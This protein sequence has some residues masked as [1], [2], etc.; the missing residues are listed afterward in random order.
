VSAIC[1]NTLGLGGAS[2]ILLL[3][4]IHASYS[5]AVQSRPGKIAIAEGKNRRSAHLATSAVPRRSPEASAGSTPSW[6][7]DIQA[8]GPH[9]LARD[10]KFSHLTTNDGLSQGYVTAILQ[11]RRGFMWFATRDGL[12][13][14]DG[15]AF[16]VYKNNPNDPGSLSSNF[17][18]DLIEDDHGDLWVATNT[19]VNKFDPTTERATRYLPDPEN[20]NSIG[21]AGVRSVAQD[22]RGY[23]W[24]GTEDSGL[25]E[26]DPGTQ[27]F[28]HYRN[29]S[30]GRFVGRITQI[31]SDKRRNI[32]FVGERGLFHLNPQT[33][34]IT[35]PRA[36]RN[37]L[38]ADSLYEDEAGNLWMLASTPVVGLVKYD[39][40]AER[41]TRYPLDP[42]AVGVLAS[43]INGGSANGSLLADGHDGLW[44]PSSLGLSYFDRQKE[45]FTYRFRHDD[46]D[47][48]SLDSNAIMSVYRDRSGVLWV[49]TENTGVN[50]LNL[51]QEQ[52]LRYRHHPGDANSISP[53]RVK[54]IY[55]DLNGVLWVGFFPRA[56]D[57]IDRKTG[58]ITHYVANGGD[59][60]TLGAGTNVNS[61]YRDAAGYLWVGGGGSGLARF[62][63]RTGRFKHYRHDPDD[64]DS[65]I[66]DNVYTIYGDRNGQMW[67][68]QEGGISRFDPATDRF[69]N[70]RPVPDIP[71]STFENTALSRNLAGGAICRGFQRRRF[72]AKLAG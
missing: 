11:D 58:T 43:T 53:G 69:T 47:P 63:E 51:R 24:F 25:D 21:G 42:R 20:P 34:Q 1:Q 50:V 33:A 2:R 36:T 9:S 49:G 38:S 57:R 32:W 70:Y 68:G 56:L 64:P 37:G 44:V 13:R 6:F 16:V 15:N 65:L 46:T 59:Q 26:F 19:G 61:I 54:A 35:C 62:D 60:N 3:C 48:D 8:Q 12:N 72:L 31:I 23:L 7:Q 5:A 22:S 67:V 55:E 30:D 27:R 29:D 14:N 66:S 4:I 45:R 18:Q 28:T 41:L 71:A 39:P 17:I 52:F 10:L 40:R